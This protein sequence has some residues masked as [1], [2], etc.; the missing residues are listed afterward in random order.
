MPAVVR[1]L[2]GVAFYAWATMLY[3]IASIM[4]AASGDTLRAAIGA[5]NG[6][7][8]SGILFLIGTTAAAATP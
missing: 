8:L 5:R 7:S 4:G 2:G 6:Y 1:E 3:M